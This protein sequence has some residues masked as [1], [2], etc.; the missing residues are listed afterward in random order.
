MNSALSSGFTRAVP[1]AHSHTPHT[2]PAG[3]RA[4]SNPPAVLHADQTRIRQHVRNAPSAN[5]TP[6]PLQCSRKDRTEPSSISLVVFPAPGPPNNHEQVAARHQGSGPAELKY[7]RVGP[8]SGN[9]TSRTG[10]A[11][12]SSTLRYPRCPFTRALLPGPQQHSHS[13]LRQLP[14]REFLT[15]GNPFARCPP[16]PQSSCISPRNTSRSFAVDY[17]AAATPRFRLIPS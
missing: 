4:S 10:R 17:R 9:S 7:P 5:R 1:P 2:R 14:G 16:P 3:R 12:P 13:R 8:S 6:L 15:I 11:A